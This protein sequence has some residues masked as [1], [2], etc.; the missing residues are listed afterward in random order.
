MSAVQGRKHALDDLD[1]FS[2][3]ETVEDLSGECEGR[4]V[5]DGSFE[6]ISLPALRDAV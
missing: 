3:A 5:V 1:P 4:Y 2:A 6:E